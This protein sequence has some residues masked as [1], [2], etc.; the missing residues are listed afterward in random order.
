MVKLV[1]LLGLLVPLLM[2]AFAAADEEPWGPEAVEWGEVDW[3]RDYAAAEAQAKET[4]KP[5]FLLF[6]EVP[7]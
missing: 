7:G 1:L 2:A 4:G 5:I 3:L 6:Q